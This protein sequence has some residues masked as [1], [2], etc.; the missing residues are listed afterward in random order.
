MQDV[1]VFVMTLRKKYI[2]SSK[3]PQ[4]Q[5]CD[6]NHINIRNTLYLPCPTPTSALG[7]T[8][9][10]VISWD[11][12]PADC[13]GGSVTSLGHWLLI[14]DS[15]RTHSFFKSCYFANRVTQL[16]FTSEPPRPTVVTKLHPTS[17]GC[18]IRHIHY[19]TDR[20]VAGCDTFTI[21]LI[22]RGN[23]KTYWRF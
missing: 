3:H 8:P 6:S 2:S 23:P 20:E 1:T 22:V 15:D 17:W 16:C 19:T 7:F 12:R 14:A 5:I 4:L 11:I 21:P 10:K 9:R 13:D 18:W